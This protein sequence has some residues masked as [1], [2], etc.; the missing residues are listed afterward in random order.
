MRC[1]S[2]S[3]Q[4][5]VGPAEGVIGQPAADEG[6]QMGEDGRGGRDGGG[7]GSGHGSLLPYKSIDIRPYQVIKNIPAVI[8]Y[9]PWWTGGRHR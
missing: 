1:E 3:W 6:G 4:S 7:T 5:S 9:R 2:L 8:R